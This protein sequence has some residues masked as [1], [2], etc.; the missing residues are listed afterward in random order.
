MDETLFNLTAT[1]DQMRELLQF[2]DIG[3]GIYVE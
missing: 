3:K 1:Y 2:I